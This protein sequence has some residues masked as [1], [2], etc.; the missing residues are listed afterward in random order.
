MWFRTDLVE[1]ANEHSQSGVKEY[2]EEEQDNAG[3]VEL[4]VAP[5]IDPG[6]V[7]SIH[8]SIANIDTSEY[9]A[10]HFGAA[11]KGPGIQHP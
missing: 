1:V 10:R 3:S 7:G 5:H 4:Q 2:I 11:D 9:G 8:K 6:D